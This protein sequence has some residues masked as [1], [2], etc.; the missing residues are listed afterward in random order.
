[1]QKCVRIL[2]T[3]LCHGHYCAMVFEGFWTLLLLYCICIR[4]H[5]CNNYCNEFL[6]KN[7]VILISLYSKTPRFSLLEPSALAIPHVYVSG[8]AQNQLF[9][10]VC[11]WYI[12]YFWWIALC[13]D[14][15][16]RKI[17][18]VE[19]RIFILGAQLSAAIE[20]SQKLTLILKTSGFSLSQLPR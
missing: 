15:K 3:L 9:V 20:R 13:D 17:D 1:M 18:A 2:R 8:G 12:F 11:V 16:T 10:S 19:A 4:G 14:P 5:N 6:I 7:R